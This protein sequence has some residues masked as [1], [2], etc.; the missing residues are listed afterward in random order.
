METVSIFPGLSVPGAV[1]TDLSQE[2]LMILNNETI[3]GS[4]QWSH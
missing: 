1:D 4:E 3:K 2:Y